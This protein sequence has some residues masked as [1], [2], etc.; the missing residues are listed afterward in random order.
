MKGIQRSCMWLLVI[1]AISG[2]SLFA[3]QNTPAATTLQPGQPTAANPESAGATQPGDTQTTVI[4]PLTPP[5]PAAA[6]AA[7]PTLDISGL[8]AL[9]AL[10]PGWN[11]INPGGSTTCARG[12]TYSFFVRK[13]NSDKLLIY[14]EGG[15]SCYN[16]ATCR[17][18]ANTFDASIDTAFDADNPALKYGGVFGLDNP[19][20]PFKDHNIVFINY[21]TGDGYMGNQ[22]VEYQGDDGAFQVNHM[23]F[24]N[25]QTVLEWT[26]QNFTQPESLFMIGCSAGVIGSYIHAPFILEH[27]KNVPATLVGDSGGGYLDGPVSLI[28]GY[29]ILDLFPAWIPQYAEL[30][31]A[32]MLRSSNF[33][34]IPAVSYPDV[35]F[36]L[37]DTSEDAPQSKLIARFDKSLTLAQVL[38]NNLASI[39]S[40]APNFRSYTGPGDYHCI[41][42]NP[43]FYEYSVNNVRLVDWFARLEARL[44][45]ENVAP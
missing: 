37:L 38:E 39:R 15:G 22:V 34:I 5:Q 26:Y 7:L 6:A 8:P 18:G 25:T 20:N 30:R 28:R 44:P 14:F 36:A 23:G 9:D 17:D 10:S 11:Q 35:R 21:C 43:V 45:V 31:T 3:P 4:P 40:S 19:S 12:G 2:C 32:E 13:T 33:F 16:A 27:Y 1:F 42:M 29:G 24:V 41:T